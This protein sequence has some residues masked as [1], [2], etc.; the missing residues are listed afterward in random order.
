MNYFSTDSSQ[1]SFQRTGT[2]AAV[3]SVFA[4]LQDQGA[5]VLG[6][7]GVDET[8]ATDSSAGINN[9]LAQGG[10]IFCPSGVTLTINSDLL[11]Y[12]N[13]TFWVQR[14]A[15]LNFNA[16]R[17]TPANA[18]VVNVSLIVDGVMTSANL[19]T[20]APQKF[21]WPSDTDG[22]HTTYERGFIEFGGASGT[23]R[24]AGGFYVGG[25]GTIS[26]D[27]TGTPSIT[28]L[29][30]GDLCRKGIATFFCDNVL[31]EIVNVYGFHGEAVYH[32][33]STSTVN[34]VV[35]QNLYVHDT[36]FNALNFNHL[37][38]ARNCYI[39]DNVTYNSYQ[40]IEVSAGDA[41][42]NTIR[43]TQGP[44]ILTGGGT[45][46]TVR[47]RGNVVDSAQMD[48]ID[49]TAASG[50]TG[51]GDVEVVG[52]TVFSCQGSA[53]NGKY[54]SR[55]SI[56]DNI[57]YSYGTT[58]S[59][60]GIWAQSGNTYADVRGNRLLAPNGGVVVP[61]RN[62]A[63]YAT[64]SDNLYYDTTASAP[65]LA[66][67]AQY[68]ASA[69]TNEY[70]VVDGVGAAGCGHSTIYK[71]GATVPL[72]A[73][74]AYARSYASVDAVGSTGASGS[75]HIATYKTSADS[76]TLADAWVVNASGQALAVAPGG[77]GYGTGA[78]G[79]VTQATSKGTAVTLNTPSGQIT[80]NNAALGAG[81][82]AVF[83][84]NNSCMSANDVLVMS[85][86]PN[87]PNASSYSV[88]GLA[89]S[90]ATVLLKN[91]SA[92]SLSDAV[93]INFAVIKGA[94]S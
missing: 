31:V 52:N 16:A 7:N 53:V 64:T 3:R 15:T 56:R 30:T 4:V 94:T 71:I 38:E 44:G 49:A 12:S 33:D 2:N 35:F 25:T 78:G 80:T 68:N 10:L 81:A 90:A 91:T 69:Q 11:F 22:V 36:N 87:S 89:S 34:N 62:Q 1:V 82:T 51:T 18:S 8:G 85:I 54:V 79:T 59:S 86:N 39:R 67:T 27:W 37:S 23:A 93:I 6:F 74:Q 84:F 17:F 20:S 24:S 32:Y 57:I 72:L 88:S 55:L 83:T 73:Q 63:T 76:T 46:Q 28:N 45:V 60:Y 58:S 66:N 26:G 40:G 92:G 29:W 43:L 48:G 42:N 77:M 41:I 19:S 5:S 13:T 61:I 9:A 70:K 14:G 65:V 50:N 21:S 75:F 47:I